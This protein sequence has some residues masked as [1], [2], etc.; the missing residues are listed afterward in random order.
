MG[1]PLPSP[2]PA[3][4]TSSWAS[5]IWLEKSCRRSLARLLHSCSRPLTRSAWGG[6]WA[7]RVGTPMGSA[8][9]PGALHPLPMAAHTLPSTRR[10]WCPRADAAASRVKSKDPGTACRSPCPSQ[11][12]LSLSR[13]PHPCP[14]LQHHCEPW[15]SG[16]SHPVVWKHLVRWL[17]GSHILISRALGCHLQEA[18]QAASLLLLCPTPSTLP[19][20]PA[21][22]PLHVALYGVLTGLKTHTSMH[23]CV[24]THTCYGHSPP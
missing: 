5:S 19:V 4:H 13:N 18:F 17:S 23:M 24:H 21:E 9:R 8:H 1:V 16:H 15:A 6:A 20:S 10:E 12:G 11:S 7:V 3:P 14:L 2:C 22:P